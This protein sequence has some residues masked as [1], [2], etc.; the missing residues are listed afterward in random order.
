MLCVRF[1]LAVLTLQTFCIR[2]V[3]ALNKKSLYKTVEDDVEK[4]KASKVKCSK[5][6]SNNV[7]RLKCEGHLDKATVCIGEKLLAKSRSDASRLWTLLGDVYNRLGKNTK[8]NKCFKE[9]AKLSGKFT[10]QIA[11]WHVIAPFQIGKPE[12]DG[13]PLEAFGGIEKLSCQKHNKD[14]EAYSELVPGGKVTWETVQANENGIVAVSYN[15]EGVASQ[16][17]SVASYEWQGWFVGDFVLNSEMTLLIQ[18]ERVSTIYINGNILA[19]DL[20]N[21]S[22]YW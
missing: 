15:L 13:D 7:L 2:N 12:I 10:G 8:A 22:Q 6:D 17:V 3:L 16:L 21:R 18:C 11:L 20:Y 19:G 5:A 1:C 9:A 14:F 4:L